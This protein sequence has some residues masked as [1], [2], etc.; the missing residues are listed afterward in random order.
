MVGDVASKGKS[1]SLPSWIKT[2]AGFWS[3]GFSTD[4]EYINAMKFLIEN[5]II[6]LD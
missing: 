5:D 6:Q 3:D 4:S 1:T 2:T